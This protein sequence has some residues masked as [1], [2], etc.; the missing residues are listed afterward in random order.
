MM[1]SLF[2]NKIF[3]FIIL[4]LLVYL[5][6][7]NCDTLLEEEINMIIPESSETSVKL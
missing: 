2:K 5:D 7:V 3:N 6:L 4:I 1:D